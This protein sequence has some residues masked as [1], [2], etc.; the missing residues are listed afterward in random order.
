[1][2]DRLAAR[3]IASLA[4]VASCAWTAASEMTTTGPL[5]MDLDP[6]RGALTGLTE[7]AAEFNLIDPASATD[8][9]L[10]RI[11]FGDETS[12]ELRP[13]D[14]A[15]YT[16][17]RENGSLRLTWKDFDVAEAPDL[18]VTV[19]IRPDAQ[20]PA[21]RWHIAIEGLGNTVVEAVH[22]PRIN[23]VRFQAGEHLAVPVWMGTQTAKART[24]LAEKGNKRMQWDYPGPLSLQCIAI[25]APDGHGIYLAG[26]DSLALFKSLAVFGD[27][28]GSLGLEVVQYPERGTAAG[29]G[30]PRAYAAPYEVVVGT[31]TG[32]WI[33][34]AERY[35]AWAVEQPWVRDSR[36]RMGLVPDWILETGLWVWN[37]GRSEQV[38]EPAAYVQ[39]R[40][41]MPVSVFWHWWH[42]CAYDTGFPE[43]FPAR[44]GTEAFQE[45]V[46][47]AERRGIRALVYMNQRLWGMTTRSWTEEGAEAY[48][49]KT[50]DGAV[51]REIYNIFT[52]A[53]CAPMCI[54]TPFWRAKYAS[55]AEEA[56][57][58]SG[59]AGIY[60]D[61]A[62]LSLPCYD[63]EHGHPL[64]GGTY[65]LAGF[66]DLTND[67]RRRCAARVPALAGEGCGE[68]WLPYLDMMLSLQVSEERY[69][70][71]D[72][73]DPIP[74][75]H[76]VYH[77]Y[78]VF[79]GNY[80]SLS[81]PPYDELW[82]AEFAP[83]E[84]L[85]LLDH[86]FARQFRLEQARALVWGQQ[87]SVANFL[88]EHFE[89]RPEEAAYALRLARLRRRALRFLLH[90]RFLRPPHIDVP[91]G[92]VDMSRLSIYAGQQD[93]LK[94]FQQ[95]HP[96]AI[97]GA[98]QAPDGDLAVVLASIADEA[99]AFPLRIAH[100]EYP[101]PERGIIR[102]IEEDGESKVSSFAKHAAELP[103]ELPAQGAQIYV[104]S[105]RR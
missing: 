15:S 34:V 76:A 64:G 96:L 14:A 105:A 17:E 23:G 74:F 2:Q 43:Y 25:W 18:C 31:F 48:A 1:M 97:A 89:K 99:L 79:Y 52:K 73:W 7:A 29:T 58:G 20:T 47:A 92:V 61:Q 95:A 66:R 32:D 68:P 26:E 60:M 40:A 81:M 102:L 98:W 37:R 33:T 56:V 45:A 5:H 16:M 49:V 9:A 54:A 78:A 103:V 21:A 59:V 67:I 44:E 86:K 82:P 27:E 35:R 8:R 75:F 19:R 11:T 38:L 24:L 65:W 4:L 104:F 41:G 6:A 70:G 71:P 93:A 85:A 10:W 83:K 88:P 39:E 62:C 100:P 55:L 3:S 13:D 101:L 30:E 69:T 57:C 87:P 12:S 42:G 77:E 53:P 94:E 80:S 63:P 22:F 90:G 91:E 50:R 51:R 84:P 36:V 72:G 46:A 28:P